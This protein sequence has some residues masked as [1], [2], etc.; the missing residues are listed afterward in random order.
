MTNKDEFYQNFYAQ[1][2]GT[3]VIANQWK[4]IHGQMEKPWNNSTFKTILEIGAGNGEHLSSVNCSFGKYIASDLRV[5]ILQ[6][7]KIAQEKNVVIAKENALKLSFT[8][9]T[10]DRVVVTC[11]LVHLP[12]PERALQEIRRVLKK[13]GGIATIYLPCEPGIFLRSVR[14]F[15]THLKAH[16]MG[17]ESITYLHFQEHRTYYLAVDHFISKIFGSDKVKRKYF[18]FRFLSW[19]WNLYAIYQIELTEVAKLKYAKD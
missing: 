16:R 18:P 10:I 5:K 1:M 7:S 4:R 19:N 11:V 14:K 8:D 15:T 2:M 3:G 6:K 12:E 9:S 13:N 17:I